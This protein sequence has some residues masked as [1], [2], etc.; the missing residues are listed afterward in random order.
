MKK[1]LLLMMVLLF[2]ITACGQPAAQ[3]TAE[4]EKTEQTTESENAGNDTVVFS[5][6]EKNKVLYDKDNIK[7]TYLEMTED[8]YGYS[9]KISYDNQ[10]DKDYDVQLRDK[11][12]NDNEAAN[13]IIMSDEVTANAVTDGDGMSISKTI[14]EENSIEKPEKIKADLVVIY[15]ITE[16]VVRLPIEI[17][18]N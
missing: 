13:I 6:D 7:I 12:L 11:S 2:A 9:L 18:F 3:E 8:D 4:E 1:L 10:T 5:V 15:D 16:E 14:L 17:N